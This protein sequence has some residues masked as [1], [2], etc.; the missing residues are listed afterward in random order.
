MISAGRHTFHPQRAPLSFVI[1]I[2]DL[3]SIKLDFKEMWARKEKWWLAL[4][5]QFQHCSYKWFRARRKDKISLSCILTEFRKAFLL[6][7]LWQIS[8]FCFIFFCYRRPWKWWNSLRK[9]SE[10][11]SSYCQPSSRW[12]TLNLW[13][14]EGLRSLLKGVGEEIIN[15]AVDPHC[16]CW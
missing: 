2:A 4:E 13:L 1:N 12:A 11:C 14:R 3:Q 16:C 6:S 5:A 7:L 8:I 10:M 9:R 15:A